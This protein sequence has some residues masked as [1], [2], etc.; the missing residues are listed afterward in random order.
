[1]SMRK[2]HVAALTIASVLAACSNS[3]PNVLSMSGYPRSR[4]VDSVDTWHGTR[5]ADPYRWL[6]DLGAAEVRRWAAAQTSAAQTSAAQPYLR[7]SRLRPW[8]VRRMEQYAAGWD[9]HEASTPAKGAQTPVRLDRMPDS[10]E[11]RLVIQSPSGV[12]RVL[13]DPSARGPGRHLALRVQS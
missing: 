2:I 9:A 7:H 4:T 12:C 1:M 3:R 6:E 13:V 11:Q 8:S 10:D 5:V